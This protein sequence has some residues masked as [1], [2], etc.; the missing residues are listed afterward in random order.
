[1]SLTNSPDLKHLWYEQH[2]QGTKPWRSHRLAMNLTELK[3]SAATSFG[4]SSTSHTW[5]HDH[6]AYVVG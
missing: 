3:G 1:M 5:R 2:K 4:A 6:L